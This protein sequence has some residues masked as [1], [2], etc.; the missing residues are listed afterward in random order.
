MISPSLSKPTD[1][2]AFVELSKLWAESNFMSIAG[3]LYSETF[4]SALIGWIFS[5][6]DFNQLTNSPISKLINLIAKKG[7]DN[8]LEFCHED[9]IEDIYY[10]TEK[11]LR[12][13]RIDI[14]LNVVL[15]SH[16]QVRIWIENKIHSKAGPDQLERYYNSI[17]NQRTNHRIYNV[18]LFFS[19]DCNN[20]SNHNKFID[21]TYQ[22]LY[23]EIFSELLEDAKLSVDRS[24]IIYLQ[25]YLKTLTSTDERCTPI[26]KSRI[27]LNI[28]KGIYDARKK[29]DFSDYPEALKSAIIEF[30]SPSEKELITQNTH[31][32]KVTFDSKSI[33]AKGYTDLAIMIFKYLIKKYPADELV[34]KCGR[35][36]HSKLSGFDNCICD[37]SE[38]K[39]APSR[40]SKKRIGNPRLYVSNQWCYQKVQYFIRHITTVFPEI[41]IEHY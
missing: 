41:K 9:P 16:K 38:S 13:G 2:P 14:L 24:N 37:I 7:D 3:K 17:V 36:K 29:Y 33:K 32:F 40:Y 30:G 31:S 8:I 25:E 1:L 27:F 6:P 20:C 10:S 19:T 4:H 39:G 11:T 34:L 22:E 15:S 35:I 21:I 28:L 12:N 23:D 5:N 26:V 18:F